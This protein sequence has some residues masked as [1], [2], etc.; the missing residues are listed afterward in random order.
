MHKTENRRMRTCLTYGMAEPYG[1]Y[2]KKL[3]RCLSEDLCVYKLRFGKYDICMEE[4]RRKKASGEQ[5]GER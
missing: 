1:D 3:T 5:R 4:E 2:F